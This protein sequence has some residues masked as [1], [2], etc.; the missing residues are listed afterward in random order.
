MQT[1]LV[2]TILTKKYA[3]SQAF[4]YCLILLFSPSSLTPKDTNQ[5][6]A[7]IAKLQEENQ[8][9]KQKI[10]DTTKQKQVEAM[11]LISFSKIVND[12]N[13]CVLQFI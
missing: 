7:E 3:V 2:T 13:K 10:T 11:G 1:Y 4:Y 8:R 6:K 12:K 5:L 9:L